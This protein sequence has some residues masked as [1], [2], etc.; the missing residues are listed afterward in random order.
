M[1]GNIRNVLR[2]KC[3]QCSKWRM[4]GLVAYLPGGA[5]ICNYCLDAHVKALN[6]FATGMPP[7]ECADC[8]TSFIHLGA[9][10]KGNIPMYIH[11]KDGMYQMLCQQ[12]SD[13]YEQK[14][15]DLYGSTIYGHLKGIR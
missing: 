9:D 8:R 3:N 6:V 4:R 7:A 14:R 13:A 11:S 5:V 10:G 15:R 1:S 2:V 12:C